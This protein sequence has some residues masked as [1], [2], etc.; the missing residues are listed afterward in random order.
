MLLFLI[1]HSAKRKK[2]IIEY[3]FH[4]SFSNIPRLYRPFSTK[5]SNCHEQWCLQMHPKVLLFINFAFSVFIRL[6]FTCFYDIVKDCQTLTREINQN[7][8]LTA[9]PQP[10]HMGHNCSPCTYK[11]FWKYYIFFFRQYIVE[12]CPASDWRSVPASHHWS[13][14]LDRS[15][16]NSCIKHDTFGFK[17]LRLLS[18]AQSRTELQKIIRSSSITCSTGVSSMALGNRW[19]ASM[20]C[21]EKVFSMTISTH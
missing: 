7:L 15:L 16:K 1:M 4:Q 10:Q 13:H 5:W 18:Q 14:W 11:V 20:Q 6:S 3:F 2:E 12:R 19:K 17:G 21:T 9:V 8:V